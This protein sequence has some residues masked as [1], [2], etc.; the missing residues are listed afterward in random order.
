[1]NN[2]C[3]KPG[4]SLK[5]SVAPLYSKLPLSTPPPISAHCRKRSSFLSMDEKLAKPQFSPMKLTNRDF[6]QTL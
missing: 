3:L 1:M 4:E 2:F 6:I 5:G